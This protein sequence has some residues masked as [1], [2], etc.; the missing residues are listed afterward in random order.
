MQLRKFLFF[1][2]SSHNINQS[3]RFVLSVQPKCLTKL[4][5]MSVYDYYCY[6]LIFL[7][8]R[9]SVRIQWILCVVCAVCCSARAR[10]YITLSDCMCQCVGFKF[11]LII[12]TYAFSR[13]Q[14]H[15]TPHHITSEATQT[16]IWTQTE[17]TT[18]THQSFVYS[19][20]IWYAFSG[21]IENYHKVN[22]ISIYWSHDRR[23]Y[24]VH[25]MHIDIVKYF[26]ST[27]RLSSCPRSHF[28]TMPCKE[29]STWFSLSSNRIHINVNSVYQKEIR[30]KIRNLR[31][32]LDLCNVYV[33]F[34]FVFLSP[35]CSFY[36]NRQ[37]CSMTRH[38]I[39]M[40]MSFKNHVSL[41]YKIQKCRC[42]QQ[43]QKQQQQQ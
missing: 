2:T 39:Y 29:A 35:F 10:G 12:C 15:A 37:K 8:F 17:T 40:R 23:W 3:I 30:S 33:L 5:Q 43:I 11:H 4:N 13:K 32:R 18:K 25:F 28:I 36:T 19:N 22:F 6:Y 7:V 27:I 26:F 24:F 41:T 14:H 42:K 31:M 9:L 34:P 21:P 16:S 38:C 20:R 1:F